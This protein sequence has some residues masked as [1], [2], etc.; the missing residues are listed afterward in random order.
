MQP[1]W[2]TAAQNRDHQRHSTISFGK[3]S[4]VMI[5]R[6]IESRH[7]APCHIGTYLWYNWMD[8]NS[9]WL[10]KMGPWS[11]CWASRVLVV[12][13]TFGSVFRNPCSQPGY[14]HGSTAQRTCSKRD[15]RGASCDLQEAKFRPKFHD[16]QDLIL[17]VS[18]TCG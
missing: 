13:Q 11:T 8:Q 1:Q 16:L 14:R 3:M 10:L 18:I 7:P 9:S 17:N 5:N 15:I 12:V 6:K 2:S 4:T